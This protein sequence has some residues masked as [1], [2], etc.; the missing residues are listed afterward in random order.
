MATYRTGTITVTNGSKAVTG[1]STLFKTAG[2]VSGDQLYIVDANNIPTG[3]LYEVDVVDS[4]TLITLKQNY[5]GTTASGQSYMIMNMAGNQTVPNFASRLAPIMQSWSDVTE[6]IN[7]TPQINGIPQ[8]GETGKIDKGWLSDATAEA[9]GVVKVGSN[10]SVADGVISVPEATEAVKGV[11]EVG[12]NISVADGVISIP[13]ASTLVKGTTKIGT[14]L[15]VADGV[16]SVPDATET[17]KGVVELATPAE[18]LAGVDTERGIAPATLTAKILG[19]VSEV[20]GVPT[21]AIIESGSNANGEYIKFADGTM[22]CQ[23]SVT[24]NNITNAWGTLYQSDSSP[25]GIFPAEFIDRPYCN[26]MWEQGS[27]GLAL[28]AMA[29]GAWSETTGPNIA[30]IRPTTHAYGG[31]VYISAIGRWF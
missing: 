15:S 1:V 25:V 31:T 14:N 16:V 6:N 10:I 24:T 7:T 22:I 2:V 26:M 12:L 3:Y 4:D 23:K 11:V 21:G 27:G 17:V 30:I 5:Q 29:S 18:V 13:D 20:D 8:A 28:P 9:K 19:T